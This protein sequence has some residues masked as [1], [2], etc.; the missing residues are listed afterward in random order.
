MPRKQRLKLNVSDMHPADKL[1]LSANALLSEGNAREGILQYTEVLFEK[2]PGHI[3]AL[4]NRC[5]GYRLDCRPDLAATDAY[6]ACQC[7]DEIQDL[8]LTMVKTRQRLLE[9]RRYLNTENLYPGSRQIPGPKG[10]WTAHPLAGLRMN[11][12]EFP[13]RASWEHDLIVGR[14]QARAIF[15]L[16]GALTHCGLSTAPDVWGIIDDATNST[17]WTKE[18]IESLSAL[19]NN[20]LKRIDSMKAVWSANAKRTN[21]ENVI[22]LPSEL[23]NLGPG[24]YCP[25]L[26]LDSVMKSRTG[27]QPPVSKYWE[28]VF[29]P[30]FS[31]ESVQEDLKL[32]ASQS[33]KTCEPVVIDSG[34]DV[35]MRAIEDH[36]PG[37]TLIYERSPWHVNTSGSTKA[38]QD[39]VEI[40]DGRLR[41]Y[42]DTCAT[43]LVLPVELVRCLLSPT[44]SMEDR[45]A[46][47]EGR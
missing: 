9:I 29:E 10:T 21:D 26:T 14:L 17:R 16:C 37:D 5:L 46:H 12:S 35:H 8:D 45:I 38:I 36:R 4:L 1:I 25:V 19:G 28:D 23:L 41:V 18:E 15:R 13:L 39:S 31:R 24:S 40:V 44:W 30:D 42:C 27:S 11:D 7:L 33:S 3:I 22:L 6:R 20:S 2:A 47:A 43:A 34:P 32:Y